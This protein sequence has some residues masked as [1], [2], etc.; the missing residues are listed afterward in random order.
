MTNNNNNN[1]NNNV[2][3][4]AILKF[5]PLYFVSCKQ[6]ISGKEHHSRCNHDFIAFYLNLFTDFLLTCFLGNAM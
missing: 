2:V 6:W 3:T 1:N 5:L 4:M